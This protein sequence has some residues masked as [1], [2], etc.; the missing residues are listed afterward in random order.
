LNDVSNLIYWLAIIGLGYV[1]VM[2]LY[3]VYM[4]SISLYPGSG[5]PRSMAQNLWKM[6]TSQSQIVFGVFSL[7]VLILVMIETDVSADVIIPLIGTLIGYIMGREF[8]D[9]PIIETKKGTKPTS[10]TSTSTSTS[11]T[12]STT[13]PPPPK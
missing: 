1:A 5:D 12:T 7:S 8:R 4:A 3:A 13:P 11:S 6:V 2:S 9:A 10:S